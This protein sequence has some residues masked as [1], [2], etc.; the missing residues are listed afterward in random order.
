MPEKRERQDYGYQGGMT[1]KVTSDKSAP[2]SSGPKQGGSGGP[3][4]GSKGFTG[5]GGGSGG[6]P[7]PP[8]SKEA[9]KK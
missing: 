2:P 4:E 5:S 6:N 3:K 1:I 7:P 8:V 9:G